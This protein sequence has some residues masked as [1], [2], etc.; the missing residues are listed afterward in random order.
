MEF[1]PTKF[2][3]RR[4]GQAISRKFLAEL[5]DVTENSIVHWEKGRAVPTDRHLFLIAAILR[6]EVSDLCEVNQDSSVR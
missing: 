6:C 4:I 1:S 5:L 3:S 2:R